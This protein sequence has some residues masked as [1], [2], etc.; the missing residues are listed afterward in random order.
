MKFPPP[1]L[2]TVPF[3]DAKGNVTRPWLDWFQ[4][5]S[6]ALSGKVPAITGSR[7]GNAAVTSLITQLAELGIVTDQTTP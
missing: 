3:Q 6:V 7:G 4:A 5:I 2:R 1:P